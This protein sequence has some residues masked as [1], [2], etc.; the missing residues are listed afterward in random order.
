MKTNAVQRSLAHLRRAGYT[1]GVVERW[2]AFAR[3]RQDLFGFADLAC[4]RADYKGTL[5][6]QC[7][8]ASTL[9]AH[10]QKVLSNPNVRTALLAGNLVRIDAWGLYTPPGPGQRGKRKRWEVR[11]EYIELDM[12]KENSDGDSNEAGD[13]DIF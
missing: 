1:C 7:C 10:R 11:Q 2:N 4:I 6:V 13:Q 9:A 3:I 12:L 5:Y 8:P